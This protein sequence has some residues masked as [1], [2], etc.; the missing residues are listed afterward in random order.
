MKTA[1]VYASRLKLAEP[2]GGKVGMAVRV[3]I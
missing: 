2:M 3:V 1:H